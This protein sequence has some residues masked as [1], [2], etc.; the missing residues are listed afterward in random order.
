MFKGARRGTRYMIHGARF[1]V[2]SSEFGV[3]ATGSVANCGVTQFVPE[4]TSSTNTL[5]SSYK[6]Y[7]TLFHTHSARIQLHT[8]HTL[9]EMVRRSAYLFA[10]ASRSM[11]RRSKTTGTQQRQVEMG[12]VM[13]SPSRQRVLSS[14]MVAFARLASERSDRDL[15]RFD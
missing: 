2:R 4:K 15:R 11:Q 7:P 12:E 9:A 10:R 14:R 13:W 3:R 1:V 5:F 8:G 6:E